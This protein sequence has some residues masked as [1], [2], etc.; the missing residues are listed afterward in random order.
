VFEAQF[1][2]DG[3][4]LLTACRD[5]MARVWDWQNGRLVSS[6]MEHRDEILTAS[7]TPDGR[8][9]VTA[10]LDKTARVWDWHSGTPMTPP[11]PLSGRGLN[12]AVTPDDS[13]AVVGGFMSALEVIPLADL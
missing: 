12:V 8:W 2:P 7:F 10:S 1:S 6:P 11:L 5:G 3:R 13:H 4:Y 9:V